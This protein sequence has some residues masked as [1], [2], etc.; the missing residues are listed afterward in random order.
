METIVFSV[1]LAIL[2]TGV[3]LYA[4]NL[5]KTTTDDKTSGVK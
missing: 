4:R 3:Y 2:G 1:F 5:G